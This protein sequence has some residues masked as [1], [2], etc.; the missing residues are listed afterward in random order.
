[1]TDKNDKQKP[2]KALGRGLSA[3]MGDYELD[4]TAAQSAVQ[5]GNS[6]PIEQLRPGR[7]QPRRH[8]DDDAIQELSDSIK[9]NGLFQPI[10]VR[11]LEKSSYEIIAGE[12][13]WRASKLAGLHEVPVIIHKLDD[14]Q[15]LA[16]A[17]LE[18]I[19]RENLSP[20]EEAEGYQR[21]MKEFDYTQETLATELGKSRSHIANLMRL[22]TLPEDV[23]RLVASGELKMGQARALIGQDEASALAQHIIEK[24]LSARQAEKLA[25]GWGT[26]TTVSAKTPANG[27]AP[28]AKNTND[29]QFSSFHTNNQGV[30]KDPDVVALEQALMQR[31]GVRVEIEESVSEEGGSGR[32]ALYFDTL[33]ELDK[34]FQHLQRRENA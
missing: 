7:F 22:L 2:K 19:Q 10:I 6:L 34:I 30:E 26:R 32:V 4:G 8:F 18:N 29:T 21:L 23:K 33:E 3:L 14:K 9:A 27:N 5:S 31:I 28:S 16:I 20:I 1:M 24:K 25:K 17:L 13:R 15:A 11:H 12:R